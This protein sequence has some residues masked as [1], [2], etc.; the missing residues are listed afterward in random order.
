MMHVL[1][2]RLAGEEMVVVRRHLADVVP[3]VETHHAAD[4]F[5]GR[6]GEEHLERLIHPR[7][8][9]QVEMAW[10]GVWQHDLAHRGRP[11]ILG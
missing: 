6:S 8:A 3:R 10:N 2:R 11:H 5:P 1:P 4:V 7:R 9:V